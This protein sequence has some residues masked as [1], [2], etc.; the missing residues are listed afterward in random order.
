MYCISLSHPDHFGL[1]LNFR[2]KK[3]AYYRRRKPLLESK[4]GY[5]NPKGSGLSNKKSHVVKWDFV[6]IVFLLFGRLN[7]KR[8]LL[9]VLTLL[10]NFGCRKPPHDKVRSVFSEF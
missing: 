5:L 3:T 7:E 6:V 8:A 2:Y 4:C 10:L 1:N 9:G